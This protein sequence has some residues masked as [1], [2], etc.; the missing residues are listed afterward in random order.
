MKTK[1]IYLGLAFLSISIGACKGSDSSTAPQQV[2]NNVAANGNAAIQAASYAT[3]CTNAA[4]IGDLKTSGFRTVYDL[5]DLDFTRKQI[6]Y[7]DGDCK[8]EA[9]VVQEKGKL[10]VKGPSP[11]VEGALNEDFNFEHTTV[12]IRNGIILDGFNSFGFCGAK[13]WAKDVEKD[14]SSQATQKTCPGKASP[15]IAY[16]IVLIK[17]GNLVLGADTEK[18]TEAERPT[19]PDL[20]KVYLKQ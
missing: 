15:R 11:S 2:K 13:D 12:T 3:V 18:T 14:V 9:V 20:S 7:T 6:Y 10:V 5:S 8:N 16:E 17:D 1:L 19:Q 4:A